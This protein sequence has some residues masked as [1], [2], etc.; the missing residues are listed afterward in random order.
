MLIAGN[1]SA[2]STANVMQGGN[3]ARAL[4]NETEEEE[5]EFRDRFVDV[6]R[7]GQLL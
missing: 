7:S 5:M 2:V 4:V 1:V 3:A 6:I